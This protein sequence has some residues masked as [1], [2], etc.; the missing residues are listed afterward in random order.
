MAEGGLSVSFFGRFPGIGSTRVALA[1]SLGESSGHAN[2]IDSARGSG[3]A[4]GLL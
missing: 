1:P 2:S 3:I 4:V